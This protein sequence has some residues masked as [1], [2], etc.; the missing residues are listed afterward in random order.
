MWYVGGDV[1]AE[2]GG[3][4]EEGGATVAEQEQ[5]K[6]AAVLP[7]LWQS[8]PHWFPGPLTSPLPHLPSSL[9]EVWW[10][11]VV[12]GSQAPRAGHQ[13]SWASGAPQARK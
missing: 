3:K 8:G 1:E 2:E 4:G 7:P 12:A 6:T 9:C 10:S 13:L 11:H 5:L